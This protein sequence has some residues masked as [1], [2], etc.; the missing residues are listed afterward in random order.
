M[1]TSAS[2]LLKTFVLSVTL[3]STLS[4][5][6]AGYIKFEGIDGESKATAQQPATKKQYKQ[7]REGRTMLLPAVQPVREAAKSDKKSLRPLIIALVMSMR[8]PMTSQLG[9]NH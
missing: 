3:A 8:L 1:K 5:H 4:A 2:I 6:G 7:P 9:F